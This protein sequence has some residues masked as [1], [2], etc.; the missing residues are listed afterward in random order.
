VRAVSPMRASIASC[1]GAALLAGVGCGGT[2]DAGRDTPS[3]L[4]PVDERNPLIIDNDSF[5]DNWLGEYAALFANRGGPRIADLI[6]S[7]SPYYGD[8]NANATGWGKL[9][10][11]ARASGLGNIPDVTTSAGLPL[12]RPADGQIDKTKAN[13]A[14]GAQLI[15]NRSRELS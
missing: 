4:L 6:A 14:M 12:V 5:N 9:V 15:V 11:A 8:A 1:I 10:A 2:L 3:G 7:A 13:N